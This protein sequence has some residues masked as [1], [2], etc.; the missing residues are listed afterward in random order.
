MEPTPQLLADLHRRMVR[1]RL[2]EEA[3]GKLA[4]Q[5]KLPE[6]I[7]Q[8]A[9]RLVIQSVEICLSTC[10]FKFISGFMS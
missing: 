3:A 1:I 5:A 7:V 9:P 10:A 8:R 2:F 4:E 6:V